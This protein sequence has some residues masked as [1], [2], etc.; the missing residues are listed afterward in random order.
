M[1]LVYIAGP[2][3]GN[4]THMDLASNVTQGCWVA[5]ELLQCG[6]PFICPML[7]AYLGQHTQGWDSMCLPEY[8]PEGVPAE[9]WYSLSLAQLCRC[10]AVLRLRGNSRGA[11]L[12]VAEANR[13]GIPV[14]HSLAD[15]VAWAHSE[16]GKVG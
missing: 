5:M 16:E 14:F 9:V 6:I 13:L 11:D 4:G 12:E 1:P 3:K 8:E 7:S 2:L 15:V 10:E